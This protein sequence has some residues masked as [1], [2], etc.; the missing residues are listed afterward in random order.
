MRSR[1]VEEGGEFLIS[2]TVLL[3]SGLDAGLIVVALPNIRS[4]R[5]E[6]EP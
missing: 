1:K 3:T 2:L 4:E 5:P 6:L